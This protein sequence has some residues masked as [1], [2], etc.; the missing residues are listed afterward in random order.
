MITYDQRHLLL[1]NFYDNRFEFLFNAW[2]VDTNSLIMIFLFFALFTILGLNFLFSRYF[3]GVLCPKTILK[4]LFVEVIAKKLNGIV[5]YALLLIIV[6]LG[7]LPFFLYFIP[8]EKFIAILV[9]GFQGY[10]I[11]LYLWL[12]SAVYIFSE[13]LFFK[14]FFCSYICPYQLVNQVTY[15]E[16]RGAYI[17]ESKESCLSC[18]ACVKVCPVED[19]DIKKGYDVRCIACGDCSAACEDIM[20]TKTSHTLIDYK[21]SKK[22]R[23]YLLSFSNKKLSLALALLNVIILLLIVYYFVSPQHLDCCSFSNEILYRY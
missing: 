13:T 14:E 18:N 4:N 16:S 7:T 12:I 9:N 5:A 17:F 3:C 21:D 19:L 15:N 23:E 11:L 22:Q 1:F 6:L 8:V 2:E 20:Q 10:S